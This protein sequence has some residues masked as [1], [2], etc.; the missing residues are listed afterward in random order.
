METINKL[1]LTITELAVYL[2]IGKNKAYQLAKS[3]GF[4]AIKLG[5]KILVNKEKLQQWLN[6]NCIQ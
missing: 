5:K 2:G 6:E 4:P 3:K 1:T